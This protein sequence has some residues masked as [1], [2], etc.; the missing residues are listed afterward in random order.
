MTAH[1]IK[2][3]EALFP[4]IKSLAMANGETV[5]EQTHLGTVKNP[6]KMMELE[7]KQVGANLVA[8]REC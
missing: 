6:I 7:S 3:E 2:V 8:I 5:E 4:Y 1:L